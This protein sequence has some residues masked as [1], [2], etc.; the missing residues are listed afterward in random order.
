M[1]GESDRI[2]GI[3]GYTVRPAQAR[4][5]KPRISAFT[6]AKID[7][8]LALKPD[9]VLGFSDL[10]ADIAADLIRAGQCVMIF[11]QRSV[12]GIL[13]MITVLGAMVGANQEAEFL[14]KKCSEHIHKI[15]Q[16]ISYP[17]PKVYFE[18]W[19]NPQ[20]SAIKW[21]SELIAIAGGIDI[22]NELSSRQDAKGRIISNLNEVV[23]RKP[24]IIIGSWCG[25]K[26]AP[27]KVKTRNDWNLVPAVQSNQIYEI[28]SADIL[29]PGPGALID[30]LS[31]LRQIIEK[32]HSSKSI[33]SDK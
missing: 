31:Q 10:Q 30:G 23:V 18:E 22:F 32:W 33:S 2:V 6:S 20:I 27:D 14:V 3:S 15:R 25:K 4:K 11:N 8:I 5:E 16:E 9:L 13:R 7:K 19:D 1:I 17:L 28:K 26:F 29:Q 12:D 21:V 24:D